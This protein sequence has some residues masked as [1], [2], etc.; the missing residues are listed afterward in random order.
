MAV[1]TAH[2][3]VALIL[4]HSHPLNVT[5]APELLHD[6]KM[7]R[8]I[9]VF[10]RQVWFTSDTDLKTGVR[11]FPPYQNTISPRPTTRARGTETRFYFNRKS[12]T[13]WSV[14]PGFLHQLRLSEWRRVSEMDQEKEWVSRR[15]LLWARSKV[16]FFSWRLHCL[17]MCLFFPPCPLFTD[18]CS[19]GTNLPVR[20]EDAHVGNIGVGAETSKC[21]TRRDSVQVINFYYNSDNFKTST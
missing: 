4:V 7:N 14:T 15:V 17:Y 8:M 6:G 5:D 2:Y 19:E 20:V 16:D 18:S 1:A 21:Q 12:S 3:S 13:C 10:H 11:L 9:R